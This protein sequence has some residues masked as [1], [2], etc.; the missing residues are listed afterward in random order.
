M[1]HL[2]LLKSSII[3]FGFLALLSVSSCYSEHKNIGKEQNIFIEEFPYAYKDTFAIDEES[4]PEAAVIEVNQDIELRDYFAWMDSVSLLYGDTSLVLPYEYLL[5]HHNPWILKNLWETDYYFLA[6][7]DSLIDDPKDQIVLFKGNKLAI[8]NEE[9]T[10]QIVLDLSNTI[11]DLNIPEYLLNIKQ[12]DTIKYKFLVRVGKN[13]QQFL[14]M[15]RNVVDLRTKK[16]EGS[17]VKVVK[18]ADFIN[19]KDNKAYHVTRRDDKRVT[20][21]PNVPWLE[22]EINGIR[23]GQLI[24]PTTNIKTLGK[25]SSNGCI[26]LREGDAWV[27]Y[28]F[29]PLGTKINIRYDLEVENELGEIT[30]LKDIYNGYKRFKKLDVQQLDNQVSNIDLIPLC[31]CAG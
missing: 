19:P 10:N 26:G 8:P 23:H 4:I 22:P 27:V 28:Y 21:L 15:A 30:N 5:V 18:D 17:I 1:L 20:G 25:A 11:L 3:T 2:S 9:M 7:K 24:H 14:A 16:G 12:Y 31:S 29:A 6:E 13:D